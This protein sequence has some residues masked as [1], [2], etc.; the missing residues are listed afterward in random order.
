MNIRT[1]VYFDLEFTGLW[2]SER[3]TI[4]EL[5]FLAVKTEDFLKLHSDSFEDN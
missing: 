1:I 4:F 3:P 5:S 2:D